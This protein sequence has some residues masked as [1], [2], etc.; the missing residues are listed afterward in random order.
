M[1]ITLEKAKKDH[2]GSFLC[3]YYSTSF[4]LLMGFLHSPRAIEPTFDGYRMGRVEK[5]PFHTHFICYIDDAERGR[6]GS[7]SPSPVFSTRFLPSIFRGE[8]KISRIS[9]LIEV[10]Q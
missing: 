6:F 9:Q 1:E 2:I 7:F 10:S 3:G 8:L 4:Y 5:T